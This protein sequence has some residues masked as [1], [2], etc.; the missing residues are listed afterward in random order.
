[1]AAFEWLTISRLWVLS[2]RFYWSCFR[3]G[4]LRSYYTRGINQRVTEISDSSTNS[5]RMDNL[6]PYGP[7]MEPWECSNCTCKNRRESVLTSSKVLGTGG[8]TVF[9][10]SILSTDE[11]ACENHFQNTHSRDVEGRYVVRLPF[12]KSVEYLGDSKKRATCL[13]HK[14]NQ[15]FE[16][17]PTYAKMYSDFIK[18]YALLKH[19][20]LVPDTMPEPPHAFYLPHH[21]VLREISLITKL[22][23]VFNG[24]SKTTSGL[25]LNDL[26][27]VGPKL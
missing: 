11:Q 21:G 9:K 7:S 5:I 17:N 15:R 1:M 4:C 10:W 12:K 19:M 3:S 18:E 6:R 2:T 24:S 8:S 14:L 22:R 20:E 27:H 26:L 23:V 13:I 25:S 16:S